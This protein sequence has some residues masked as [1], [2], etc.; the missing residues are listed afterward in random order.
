MPKGYIFPY[1]NPEKGIRKKEIFVSDFWHQQDEE[2]DAPK[3]HPKKR[4]KK[5]RDL[6]PPFPPQRETLGNKY[7]GDDNDLS[8]GAL[9]EERGA[10]EKGEIR[11]KGKGLRGGVTDWAS[12]KRTRE[13]RRTRIFSP[14]FSFF[15]S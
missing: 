7:I 13:E 15:L 12:R 4:G 5:S 14:L 8:P 3:Y 1:R 6:L 9:E 2:E 10:K 11:A